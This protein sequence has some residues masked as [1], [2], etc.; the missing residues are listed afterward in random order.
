MK[1]LTGV[2]NIEFPKNK[3]FYY[4]TKLQISYLF[5]EESSDKKITN[6]RGPKKNQW[7]GNFKEENQPNGKSPMKDISYLIPLNPKITF[8]S[9]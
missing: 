6:G 3:P 7:K 1:H 8:F 2:T 5:H 4:T 9:S